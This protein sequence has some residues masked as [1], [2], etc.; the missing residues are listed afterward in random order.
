MKKSRNL[1]FILCFIPFLQWIPFF[2]MNGKLPKKKWLMMGFAYLVIMAI[3]IALPF[4]GEAYRE[5]N[6]L[7]YPDNSPNAEDYAGESPDLSDYFEE[8]YWEIEDYN[9][10]PE[11]KQYSK[12]YDAWYDSEGYKEY[13]KAL[14]EWYNTA[15]YKAYDERNDALY[16]VTRSCDTAQSIIS[17]SSW[18]V[19]MILGFFVERYKYNR[20]LDINQNRDAVYGQLRNRVDMMP[21]APQSVNMLQ[22]V[23]APAVNMGV[24]AVHMDEPA[25]NVGGPVV[26]INTATEEELMTLPGMKTIDAKKI[27]AYRQQKGAFDSQEEFFTS[28]DAK[29]Y[30]VVKMQKQITLQ[31]VTNMTNAYAGQ[32]AQA[33]TKRRFDL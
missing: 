26:N 27:I 28:F 31:R 16:V 11:Y 21:S 25:I 5:N 32:S 18:L 8:D 14:Q 12:D 24:E 22:N 23:E 4:L 3:A 15:E 30:I 19:F 7:P 29:P 1:F 33:E 2:I 6:R 9:K 20:E 17:I 10:T 13:E